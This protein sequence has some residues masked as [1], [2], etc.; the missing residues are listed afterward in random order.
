[1]TQTLFF[2]LHQS[3][4]AFNFFS[5]SSRPNSPCRRTWQSP[6]HRLSSTHP[7]LP[8]Q[9]RPSPS[10]LV[11]TPPYFRRP[12]FRTP[13]SAP[14]QDRS[15]IARAPSYLRLTEK[16]PKSER[17]FLELCHPTAVCR[18][19]DLETMVY[20]LKLYPQPSPGR[21]RRLL[22]TF[23]FENTKNKQEKR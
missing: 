9:S 1:M 11:P 3:N 6:Y 15:D 19:S 10:T 22:R 17:T 13:F 23:A 7:S 18:S 21:I 12:H 14:L 20:L 4:S 8:P 5:F 2:L 16:A